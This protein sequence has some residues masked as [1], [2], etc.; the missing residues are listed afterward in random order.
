VTNRAGAVLQLVGTGAA[1]LQVEALIADG[2]RLVRKM[3]AD[4]LLDLGKP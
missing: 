2:R 3:R 1:G 4:E